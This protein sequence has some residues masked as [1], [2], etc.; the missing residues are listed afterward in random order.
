MA[1]IKSE[2]A[3]VEVEKVVKT[4]ETKNVKRIIIDLE[5]AGEERRLHRMLLAGSRNVSG[6]QSEAFANKVIA[7]LGVTEASAAKQ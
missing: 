6:V 7:D 2:N 1:Q 4:T 5:N 3:T